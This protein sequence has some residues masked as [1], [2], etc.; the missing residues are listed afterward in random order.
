MYKINSLRYL[1]ANLNINVAV[2]IYQIHILVFEGG[3][4]GLIMLCIGMV[5]I[6]FELLF[7]SFVDFIIFMLRYDM[8]PMK[9]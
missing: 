7:E 1:C 2:I 8:L 3:Y 4:N 5:R 6:I 9:R